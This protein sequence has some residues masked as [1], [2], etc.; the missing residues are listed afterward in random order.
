MN[1]NE[2][3]KLRNKKIGF[4]HFHHLLSEFTALE[5]V[6]INLDRES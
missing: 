4:A 5:N 2:L 6:L 1:N 3:A